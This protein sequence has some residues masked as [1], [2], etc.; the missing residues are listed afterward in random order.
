MKVTVLVKIE[1]QQTDMP[2]TEQILCLQRDELT[3]ENLGLTLD[4]AKTL[5]ANLQTQIAQI[6]TAQHIDTH[7]KCGEC[8]RVY[9]IKDDIP[10]MLIEEATTDP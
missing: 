9:P 7:R 8:G 5:L 3:A 1:V 10:V 2:L 4:E 6:Q